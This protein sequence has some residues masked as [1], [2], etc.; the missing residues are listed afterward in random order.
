M[1]KD[2]AF[3]TAGGVFS[4]SMIKNQLAKIRRDSE[5]VSQIPHPVEFKKYFDL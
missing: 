2:H 5:E 1:E 4:E 3:L